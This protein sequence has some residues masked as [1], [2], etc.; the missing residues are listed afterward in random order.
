MFR[1]CLPPDVL[2]LSFRVASS[3]S[4]ATRSCRTSVSPAFARALHQVALAEPKAAYD[5]T[6]APSRHGRTRKRQLTPAVRSSQATGIAKRKVPSGPNALASLAK[7]VLALERITLAEP[8]KASEPSLT[9]SD[10]ELLSLYEDLLGIQAQDSLPADTQAAPLSKPVLSQQ[11][12][13]H[14]AVL[15]VRDRLA[16]SAPTVDTS[17]SL[18]TRLMQQRGTEWMQASHDQE[19]SVQSGQGTLHREVIGHIGRAISVMDATRA[20][21]APEEGHERVRVVLVSKDEWMSL[22]NHCVRNGDLLAGEDVL[23]L[24]KRSGFYPAEDFQNVVLDVYSRN[25]D[26]DNFERALATIS[27]TLAISSVILVLAHDSIITPES[28][29]ETQRDLHV[30]AYLVR[31]TLA[32]QAPNAP[33]APSEL[34]RCKPALDILHKY[35]ESA[36]P[37][38]MRSYSR[39]ISQLAFGASPFTLTIP[40]PGGSSGGL[41]KKRIVPE[42]K[43]TSLSRAHA[44]DLFAHMRYVAHPTPDVYM[45]ADMMRCAPSPEMALDLWTE[46]GEQL[47]KRANRTELGASA[48]GLRDAVARGKVTEAAAREAHVRAVRRAYNAV[49]STCARSGEVQY[50][51]EAF[52]LLREMVGGVAGQSRDPA[53]LFGMVGGTERGGGV[54]M[55][56]IYTFRALLEA[57]RRMGD[58]EKA[59]WI[60]AEIVRGPGGAQGTAMG[61]EDEI[62]VDEQLMVKVFHTYAAYRPPFKRNN[63]RLIEDDDA[64]SMKAEGPQPTEQETTE[65]QVDAETTPT[66]ALESLDAQPGE[67]GPHPTALDIP[68]TTPSFSHLP[69]QTSAEVISEARALF[70]RILEDT[71]FAPSSQGEPGVRDLGADYSPVP[72]KFASVQLSA[73]LLNAYMAVFYQHANVHVAQDT[74]RALWGEPA[75]HASSR[76]GLRVS[77]DAYTYLDA[78][79]WAANMRRSKR[80]ERRAACAFAEKLWEGWREMEASNVGGGGAGV[81]KGKCSARVVEKVYAAL[82]RVLALNNELDTAVSILRTFV[83]RYPASNVRLPRGI[84]ISASPSSSTFPSPSPSTPTIMVKPPMLSTRTSLTAAQ[85]PLVRMSTPSTIGDDTVP[86]L[87]TFR[88]LE[89]LHHRLMAAGRRADVRYVTGVTKTYEGALKRRRD[90]WMKAEPERASVGRGQEEVEAEAEVNESGEREDVE[91]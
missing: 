81:G 51:H 73:P 80:E 34:D 74:F 46:L 37:A 30:R 82:I 16:A 77:R 33:Q 23:G 3:S 7:K 45:Y 70:S 14:N 29:T 41:Q 59:R 61:D 1:S 87:L 56:D 38:P 8:E 9:Y 17:H 28:P 67:E 78:L 52:R 91:L 60:L 4:Q 26:V 36:K 65:A 57:A 83:A 55:P 35:E 71:P 42:R 53:S 75:A 24:M 22:L 66:T 86:P 76:Q 18:S 72:R 44:W 19:T 15:A 68:E 49:I 50:V 25:G 84:P 5:P 54:A 69:P 27:G 40:T 2:E 85:R 31:D 39:V 10:T 88:D 43:S 13:D 12:Q 89:L 63:T 47:R 90:A 11:E 79:E 21:V 48:F 32:E 62:R 64:S 6:D 58:L 20:A